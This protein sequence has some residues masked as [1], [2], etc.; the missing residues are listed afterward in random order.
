MVQSDDAPEGDIVI[1]FDEEH[2]ELGAP[3]AGPAEIQAAEAALGVRL[4]DAYKE[5]VQ[6]RNGGFVVNRMFVGIPGYSERP[7]VGILFLKGVGGEEG[8]DSLFQGRIVNDSLISNWGYPAQSVNIA[9]YNHGGV[10]LDYSARGRFEEPTVAYVDADLHP[11]VLYYK[12]AP[13]FRTFIDRFVPSVH[14]TPR[15]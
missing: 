2:P 7:N 1:L 14:D 11:T 10:V 3:T 4:P 15:V 8:I 13:D 5:L 9:H 6:R 12:L